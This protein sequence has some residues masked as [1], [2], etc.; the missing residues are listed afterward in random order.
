MS[1]TRVLIAAIALALPAC[2]A[3]SDQAAPLSALARMP[4]KEITVFKDGH[5]FAMHQG[6]MPTDGAGN[7]LMDYLPTPVLGAFW[8]FSADKN[9][10]LSAVVA[11]Q[12]KVL[13]ERT[14]LSVRELIEGNIGAQAVITEVSAGREAAPISYPA[15]I[16][17]VPVRSSKELEDTSPP[18]SPEMLPQKGNVVLLKTAEGTK[19]VPFER[20]SD[21]TFKGEPKGLSANEEFRNLLTL[22]L[23]WPGTSWR[24]S[25]DVGL[26]YLQRGLRWIPGYKVTIDGKG[27]AVVKL[28]ATLINELTDLE[29][30][31]ANLVIGVPTFA[32]AD[33]IDPMA[34][35]Q[36]LA[37]LSPFFRPDSSGRQ[38]LSNATMSQVASQRAYIAEPGAG[39]VA[40]PNL[41]P[42]IAGSQRSEDLFIFTVKHITLKKGQR[43]VI[44]VQEF[45]L[46]YKDVYTLDVPFT[47]PPEVWRQL[48]SDRQGELARLMAR[49]TVMHKI[50]L[51]NKSNFPLTTAPALIIRDDQVLAQGMMT[52]T[53]KGAETDLAITTAVDV[54]VKKTDKET[55][56]APNA[57]N[58][59][60][61]QYMRVDLS[62]VLKLTNYRTE[63]VD[64][65]V[66]RY[67]LGNMGEADHD[68]K[69]SMVNVFEDGQYA[70]GGTTP[71]WWGWYNWPYWWG[72]FNGV[73]KIEWKLKLEP[74]ADKAVELKYTW[75]YYWR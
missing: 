58:W 40:A 45:T 64:L 29:D 42:E 15:T 43:M 69:A 31:T 39:A 32:F 1:L 62:G 48:G 75:N 12:R 24:S 34:L 53:A 61:D 25:A 55:G 57:V 59:Q 60:G 71:Y 21:V 19:V 70:P 51:N 27:G 68:G 8:P 9:V 63:A 36:A 2:P 30:V 13:V 67:V 18:N 74:G 41:G 17:G 73:G 66:T 33:Q 47:P 23:E 35:Q 38:Y 28:Q 20:I 14:S 49:P 11:S 4:V 44:P 72:H 56:R 65:E 7:V 46:T 26:F 54:S 6:K 37:Q 10:K 22:K 52:Y 50:R 16:A 5:A 3:W